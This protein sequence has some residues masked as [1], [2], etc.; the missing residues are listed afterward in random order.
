MRLWRITTRKWALDTACQGARLYGG[1]WNP[2]GT[3]ALYAG[4]TIELCAL[5]KFVHL[6][7]AAHPPLVLVALDLPDD[8]GLQVRPALTDLPHD[9][10]A[11][12]VPASSQ[13]YGRRWLDAAA[14]L[15]L[16]VP[17]AI[18]PESTNAVINPLHAAY[19]DVRLDIVREFSFDVR[20]FRP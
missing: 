4:S 19:R 11:L 6:G 3:P 2:I 17:S 12:P 13:L 16:L 10:A 1:R 5:E 15:V 18:I 9:W 8:P 20:M 7:S 14:H